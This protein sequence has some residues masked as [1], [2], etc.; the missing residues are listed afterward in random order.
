MDLLTTFIPPIV[1]FLVCLLSTAVPLES[2]P[3]VKPSAGCRAMSG[4]AGAAPGLAVSTG[5]RNVLRQLG[6]V[7][8]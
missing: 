5:S 8:R 6:A 1:V 7:S 3:Q 2:L 4:V